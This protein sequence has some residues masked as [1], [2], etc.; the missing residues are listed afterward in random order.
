MIG[1]DSTGWV[2]FHIKQAEQD[3][4]GSFAGIYE[5]RGLMTPTRTEAGWRS[6]GPAE[7]QRAGEIVALRALGLSLAQ[8]ASVLEGE[9]EGLEPALRSRICELAQDSGF[10]APSRSKS[11]VSSGIVSGTLICENLCFKFLAAKGDECQHP[12]AIR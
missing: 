2:D 8:V 5:Q 4:Q 11:A 9:A 3:A 1:E 7:M 10:R 12:R 6:Y